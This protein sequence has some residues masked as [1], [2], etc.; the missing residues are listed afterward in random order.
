MRV[1]RL[2]LRL[3]E[4]RYQIVDAFWNSVLRV[5]T[6]L[7]GAAKSHVRQNF[8]DISDRYT[9]FTDNRER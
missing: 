1:A 9:R 4:L 2:K 3:L 8:Y 6:F 5:G 7:I